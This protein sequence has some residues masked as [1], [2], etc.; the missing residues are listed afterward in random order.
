MKWF[1][2]PM[3]CVWL[4]AFS[5][6]AVA[7]TPDE[8]PSLTEPPAATF[9]PEQELARLAPFLEEE[10]S[11][12]EAVRQFDRVQQRFAAWDA[13]L[14]EQ[15]A[16]EGDQD[17]ARAASDRSQKRM[18]TVKTAYGQ[19]L[20]RYPDNARAHNFLGE[21]EYDWLGNQNAA[22]A[23]WHRSRELDDELAAPRNNLAIH[24]CHVGEYSQ[25][26]EL[27]DEALALDPENPD[28]L[29]N[30]AQ[31][32]LIHPRHV[33]AHYGIE[34]PEVFERAMAMSRKATGL[35][36]NDYT[37]AQ[38]YAV[39]YFAGENF[40]VEVKWS[41]AAKAWQAARKC[42]RRSDELF[43]TWLNEGRVWLRGGEN[44]EAA[45]CF[46]EALAIIPTSEIAQQLL[47]RAGGS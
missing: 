3:V 47:A 35:Q 27:F 7:D 6:A 17:L 5:A 4:A 37:L 2:V 40:G 8:T 44:K 15:Y 21:V 41:D 11:A 1:A 12:I 26:L 24:Y 9:D 38:D 32:F 28:Y 39:N 25:C 18:E 30:L 45:R 13:D 20:T 29:F 36:P 33:Q 22:L 42:V 10:E 16:A 31:I 19:V 14:S 34:R 46:R 43:Y 23:A